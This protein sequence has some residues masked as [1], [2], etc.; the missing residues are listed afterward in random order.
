MTEWR[1]DDPHTGLGTIVLEPCDGNEMFGRAG[2][3]IHGDSAAH[4]KGASHGCII[5][6]VAKN[7]RAM[8][9]TGDHDLEVVPGPLP[10]K[11]AA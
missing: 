9:D 2:F 5:Y 1:D 6:G 8:W 11:L 7:R 3:R 10:L 4:N